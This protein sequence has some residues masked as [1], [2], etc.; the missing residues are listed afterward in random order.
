MQ[1]IWGFGIMGLLFAESLPIAWYNHTIS[2]MESAMKNVKLHVKDGVFSLI[3]I[4]SAFFLNL[5]MQTWFHTQSLIPMIFVLGVFLIS[6]RT[7]GYF[8]GIAASLISVLAV[9]YAFTFPYYAFDLI[10]PECV[11]SAVVMLVVSILTG[12][13]T[14]QI[15]HQEKIKAE[16]ERERMRGNLLRAVSHDLRTPLTSIYGAISTVIENYQNLSR[17]QHLELL[18]DVQND[19]EWLIRMVENLLSVTRIDGAGVQVQKIP[20]VL[21]ELIDTVLVKAKKRWPDQYIQV[22]IPDEFVSIPMD[23]M[24]IEQVLINVLENAI[25]HAKGMTMLK[26]CVTCANG[27]A[28]FTVIDDGCGI[29]SE[30]MEQLFTGYLERKASP[31]DGQRNNMGIGLSVCATI[32]K[33]HG[34]EIYAKNLKPH[35]AQFSFSLEMEDGDEQ[36]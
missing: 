1:G 22:E 16:A 21:E 35:G 27:L 33:A 25:V 2:R 10:S 30:R 32:I 36:Q 34:S 26:I 6:W 9:N 19:S 17:E 28:N 7:Q 15:K 5:L 20:T 23:A 24:L 13:L 3:T 11:A 8:W 14:T 4:V 29:A 12:T 31:A 18:Q